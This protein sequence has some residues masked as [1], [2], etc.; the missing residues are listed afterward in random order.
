MTVKSREAS[1]WNSSVDSGG[2]FGALGIGERMQ[3]PRRARHPTR[4]PGDTPGV[5]KRSA[6]RRA[7]QN[8][9]GA[10]KREEVCEG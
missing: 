8:H 9:E 2:P 3:C 7:T 1:S 6:T 5:P 4:R 10:R